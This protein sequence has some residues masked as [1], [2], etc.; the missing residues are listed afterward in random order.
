ML[1]PVNNT[2]CQD[3]ACAVMP[4]QKL[5]DGVKTVHHIKEEVSKLTQEQNEA[6]GLAVYIGMSSHET[7]LYAE[8][9]DRIVNLLKELQTLEAL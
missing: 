1:G 2:I 6:L 4:L 9:H 8:R 7:K 5:S 3:G